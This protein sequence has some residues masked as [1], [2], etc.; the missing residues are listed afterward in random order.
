MARARLAAYAALMLLLL[1][2]TTASAVP[3]GAPGLGA[4]SPLAAVAWAPSSGLLVA[5]VVTGGASASD[6]LIELT[7][8]SAGPLDLAGLEVVYATSSGATVTRKAAWTASLVLEPGRHVLIANTLGTY[9]SLADATYSGGLAATGGAIALRAI[10]G[11]PIDAVGWGD[12]TNGFVEGTAVGAPAAGS[13]IERRPGGV[14]G[15]VVDT[16]DNMSDFAVNP[17]P[18]AQ[19]LVSPPVPAPVAVPDGVPLADD[20]A[21]P[22][23]DRHDRSRPD[24]HGNALADG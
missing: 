22:G 7:N 19:N 15:N 12:A 8:A 10:G 21:R 14:G 11:A 24:A 4:A 6:E 18:M 3:G 13:S 5:E 23:P 9:A 2:T 1:S 20:D 17:S 16:N